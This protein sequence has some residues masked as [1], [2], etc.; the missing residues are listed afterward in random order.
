MATE[1]KSAKSYSAKKEHEGKKYSGMRV[2][3][4]HRWNYPDGSWHERKNS[5][6]KW[7]FAFASHKTRKR[8]AP[9]GSGAGIGSEY[10][11]LIVA[12]QWVRKVDANTYA[13]VMEGEKHL[14]AFKKPDWQ[15]WNTQFK[16]QKDARQKTI[17]VLKEILHRLETEEELEAIEESWQHPAFVNLD[18]VPAA[19]DV[20]ED[21]A[22]EEVLVGAEER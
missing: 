12:D 18:I 10:H 3:G 14:I 9:T 19:R 2:G 20:I 1:G 6:S 17:K 8:K 7:D 21:L 15:S 16:N 4:I 13:T 11:W 5:P 22:P